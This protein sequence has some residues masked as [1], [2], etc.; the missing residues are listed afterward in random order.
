MKY[1]V[2]ITE[3]AREEVR[4]IAYYLKHVLKSDQACNNFKVKFKHQ[5][6]LITEMPELYGISQIPVATNAEYRVAPVNNYV[7]L[8]LFEN[9]VVTIGHVFHGSQNY[10]RYI[11]E[12]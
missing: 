1:E 7:I 6:D 8:Y 5:V 12:E 2:Y 9:D 4:Q 11:Y 10:G 3:T